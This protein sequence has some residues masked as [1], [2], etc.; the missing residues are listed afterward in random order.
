MT[1]KLWPN[2]HLLSSVTAIVPLS[3]VL[4]FTFTTPAVLVH[5]ISRR[6]D[7]GE[8]T[9]GVHAPVL[10]QKLREAALI[11]VC[12]EFFLKKEKKKAGFIPRRK[13]L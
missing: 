6:T 10:T 9:R 4:N 3:P 13:T 5:V 2:E 1:S 7:A 11:Q 8:R 12:G